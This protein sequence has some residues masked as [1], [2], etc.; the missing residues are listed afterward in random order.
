MNLLKG[1]Y[2]LIISVEEETKVDVGAL[3]SVY[4]ER[5]IYAYVGSA[6]NNLRK[7]IERHLRK[8][9]K[10]FWHIDYLLDNRHAK[11]IRVFYKER[12][13]LEECKTARELNK[14]GIPVLNFGCSDCDCVSHLFMLENFDY[15]SSSMAFLTAN[16]TRSV[17]A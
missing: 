14:I 9:K 6:Q 12:D 16:F 7:R 1:I 4:F 13:K 15:S 2:L 11:I 8:S 10:K 5:G 3:S 17:Q